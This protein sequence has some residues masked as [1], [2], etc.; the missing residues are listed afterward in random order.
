MLNRYKKPSPKNSLEK[1]L[2]LQT[3]RN[4]NGLY[5]LRGAINSS[6]TGSA[7]PLEYTGFSAYFDNTTP[8]KIVS[9]GLVSDDTIVR[10]ITSYSSILALFI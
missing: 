2:S 9:N 8:Q 6:S 4:N 7:V 1:R 3:T 5:E 10:E